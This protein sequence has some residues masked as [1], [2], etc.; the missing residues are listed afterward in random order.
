MV[1]N[2]A[3]YLVGPPGRTH[4]LVLLCE[5]YGDSTDVMTVN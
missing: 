3:S 4:L 5:A 1:Q 2:R